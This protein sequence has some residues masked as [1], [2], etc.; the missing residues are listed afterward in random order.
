MNNSTLQSFKD[1]IKTIGTFFQTGSATTMECLGLAGMDYAIIDTEHGPFDVESTAEFIRAAKLRQISP[2]VRVKD[3]SRSSILKMLDIGAEA[4]IVPNVHSLDEVKE[5]VSHGKYLP[6]GNR[7]F[8][9]GRACGFGYMDFAK[10]IKQYMATCNREALIIPQCETLGSLEQIEAITAL[11][12]VDG[13]FVGPFDLS[14][15]MGMLGQFDNTEFIQA[16][17]RILKACK[18]NNKISMIFASSIQDAKA[19]L[20][21]GFDSVA[22]RIDTNIYTEAV[23]DIVQAL[24]A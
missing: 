22:Y 17:H 7:G 19:K 18:T 15:S 8:G 20:N 11:E 6:I 13:I 3:S 21:Q 12:G 10:D 23:M 16:V 4:I 2:F 9:M 24:R 14:A 5:I 1:G